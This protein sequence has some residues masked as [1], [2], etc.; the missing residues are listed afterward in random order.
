MLLLSSTVT[1]SA[2]PQQDLS[3]T[4]SRQCVG[5]MFWRMFSSLY[6]LSSPCWLVS[7]LLLYCLWIVCQWWL[8]MPLLCS[9][10]ILLAGI[11]F[12][13]LA[14]NWAFVNIGRI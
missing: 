8:G 11:K 3:S 7:A 6:L 9:E 13:D 2:P 1:A 14:P 4:N 12:G 5:V 10:Q